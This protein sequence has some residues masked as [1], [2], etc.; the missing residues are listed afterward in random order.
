M[1]EEKEVLWRAA[2]AASATGGALCARGEA[3][4]E[5][6][7]SPEIWEARG[8]S[9][10]TR[11]LEK[12]DLFVALTGDA[13]DGHEF[14][15]PAF[16]AGAAAALVSRVPEDAPEGAPLLVAD[17]TLVGLER[18]GAA[19]RARNS[20]RRVAVTGSVGKTS[21]K[22]ML[23][24]TLSRS[25]RTH[26][27]VKSYNNHWGVPLTLARMPES[28]EY[29]VFEIG[30]NHAGEITP[31]TKMVSPDVAIITTVGEAHLEFFENVQGIARAKAEIFAGLGPEGVAILNRDNEHFEFLVSQ[32]EAANVS[33]VVSFGADPASDIKL[34][35]V[36]R[37][38]GKHFVTAE[39]MGEWRRYR[40]GAPGRHQVL[41]SL[42]VLGAV[43]LLGGSVDGAVEALAELH[44][45]DGR[46]AKTEVSVKG[47]VATL[48][49]ESYNANPTSMAAALALLAE[50]H[51]VNGGRRVAVLG[52]MREL[53]S[54]SAELH[55]KLS[56]SIAHADVGAV[57]LAGEEMAY[58]RD[59]LPKS[60]TVT[61]AEK[62]ADLI[63]GLLNDVRPGDVIMV[64]G[65][66]ASGMKKVVD[67]FKSGSE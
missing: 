11:T 16:Q 3:A 64:K 45:I 7:G 53:G 28:S 8:V 14:V 37:E 44:A 58:L 15:A 22:E 42:A 38:G 55:R 33:R 63:D 25:G 13:R 57:Y 59:A 26:A 6:L 65:S 32:A 4:P 30:M 31:L 1:A 34:L 12:G 20:A 21:V 5:V 43:K 24:V 27:S 62:S 23:R 39:I 49:D 60:L 66:L 48:V 50:T 51:P 18:L 40:L 67:A 61:Y 36:I 54:E 56:T 9:I 47:G 17:D 29:G 19:A 46:G 35:D 52:D 41:N 2:E 10:D